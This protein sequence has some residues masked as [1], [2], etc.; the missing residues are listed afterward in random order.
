MLFTTMFINTMIQ[1]E[2]ART[3]V[4]PVFRDAFVLFPSHSVGSTMAK[5]WIVGPLVVFPCGSQRH[6]N[7]RTHL[8]P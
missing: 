3:H 7:P 4:T 2:V 6:L 8:E 5:G 1:K